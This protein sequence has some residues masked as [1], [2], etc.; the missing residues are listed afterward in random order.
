MP[1]IDAPQLH[2]PCWF[3]LSTSD[4]EAAKSLYSELFGWSYEDMGPAFG[5]YT[6]ARTPNGRAAAAMA[7]KMPGQEEMPTVW[8]VYWGTADADAT[9]A[10]I[11][12]NGGRMMVPPMEIPGSGR[13]AIATDPDGAVFGLWQAD[14]FIGAEIE[15]E[16]GS[17]CWSEVNS[18]NGAGN[19]A[20][21]ASVFDL[22]VHKLDM[23]GVVYHTVHPAGGGDAVAGVLQ[24]D[25]HWAGIPPNW[26]PY[27]AVADLDL[28][29]AIWAKHGGKIMAGPIASPYG[30][31]MVV[32]DPQGGY[33]SYMAA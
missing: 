16:H 21:Y 17:M 13:M 28:A 3:D 33:L 4:V 26:M 20:F 18:R 5:H 22:A 31:I 9:V 19:A 15:G 6:I 27:F 12:A 25:E 32:Q 11:E 29:N 7:P 10:R 1:L 24:M 14:P 2:R 30:R 23:P 8:T